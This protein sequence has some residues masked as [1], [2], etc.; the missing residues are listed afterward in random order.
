MRGVYSVF[1]AMNHLISQE[2]FFDP[3]KWSKEMVTLRWLSII[4]NCK[5]HPLF[6]KFIDLVLQ[7]DKYKLGLRIPGFFDNLPALVEGA[8]RS[9]GQ[10]FSYNQDV[11]DVV[12]GIN[13]WACVKYI[14]G[15]A[16]KYR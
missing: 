9:Y 2:R 15:L 7:G 8:K 10:L 3:R 5:W 16:N 13:D 4:E 1:R 11:Q 14:K 6:H 12:S